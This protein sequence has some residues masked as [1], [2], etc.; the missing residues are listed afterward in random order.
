MND[1]DMT[2]L[3]DLHLSTLQVYACLLVYYLKMGNDT[4]LSNT[5]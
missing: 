1:L 3:I 4:F 5:K 2:M